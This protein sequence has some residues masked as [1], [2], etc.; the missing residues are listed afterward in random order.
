LNT[1]LQQHPSVAGHGNVAVEFKDLVAEGAATIVAKQTK[2]ND[3]RAK[4]AQARRD[5]A[6]AQGA[7]EPGSI[8]ADGQL[9]ARTVARE[10][11]GVFLVQTPYAGPAAGRSQ[12]AST[13]V[14]TA[15]QLEAIARKP[16]RSR[17]KAKVL[18]QGQ[19]TLL[20]LPSKK[21]GR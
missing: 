21:K 17:K 18:P 4:S 9:Q 2:I 3:R 10:K 19:A 5:D 1:S 20:L 16:A 6:K 11:E 7:H 12:R 15:A 13:K 14:I 8:A